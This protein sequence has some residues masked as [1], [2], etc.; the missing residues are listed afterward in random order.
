[1]VRKVSNK[2]KVKFHLSKMSLFT[3]EPQMLVGYSRVSTSEQNSTLQEDA[4]KQVG[5]GKLFHDT[6][7]G[8][9]ATRPGLASALDFLREND[10][11]VVWRLDRLGRSLSDL[12]EI[13]GQLEKRGIGFRSITESIDTTT[14]GGKLV[15]HV[16]GAMAEFER[17][18]IRERTKAGL[19]AARQRGRLGGR[20]K[21][22]S[23]Q[24]VALAK[25][26]YSEKRHTIREICEL[27]GVTKPCLYD[28]LHA[29]HQSKGSK[30]QNT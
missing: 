22:L 18:L 10:V 13:V 7:S 14:S 20:P 8:A 6:A 21:A 29:K 27:L 28:Y 15:F 3:M 9:T 24:K 19:S 4:L 23:E 17:N 5:C 11:L 16:F 1:M 2:I 30:S 25:Q 12:L 26:L